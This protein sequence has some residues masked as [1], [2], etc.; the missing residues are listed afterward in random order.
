MKIT[1]YAAAT[2]ALMV[3]VAGPAMAATKV[4]EGTELPM[5]LEETLSSKTANEG[6]RVTVSLTDDVKLS[7][8]TVLRAGY[9]GVGEVTHA[10]KSGNMGKSGQLSLSLNYLKVGDDRIKLRATKA[11]QGKGNTTNQVVGVVFIG[12]FAAFIK[13]HSV[14]IPKGTKITA[15]VDQDA[16][17]PTPLPPP[18]AEL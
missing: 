11:S 9:R 8:G 2:A 13:G 17:L 1:G 6:D 4:S 5:R 18:P 15:Y 7:D 14:E 3:L 10:R 12:V 16:M